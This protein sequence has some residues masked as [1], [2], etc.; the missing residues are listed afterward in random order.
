MNINE[1][2]NYIGV[3]KCTL[4]NWEKAGKIHVTRNPLNKYRMYLKEDLD[5]ILERMKK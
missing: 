2:S 1:A 3:S 4:R 5:K